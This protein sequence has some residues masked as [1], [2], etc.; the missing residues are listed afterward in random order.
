[1]SAKFYTGVMINVKIWIENQGEEWIIKRG[2]ITK[3]KPNKSRA[4]SD[5]F[6][7]VIAKSFQAKG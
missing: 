2:I 7:K 1:M 3:E 4:F 5:H 6:S